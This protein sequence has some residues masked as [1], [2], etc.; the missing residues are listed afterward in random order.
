M[1]CWKLRCPWQTPS[2]K[3][4]ATI[5]KAENDREAAAAARARGE[6]EIIRRIAQK[7][8]DSASVPAAIAANS[9]SS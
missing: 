1:T 5:L 3:V 6:A 4:C 9:A 8:V 2:N 7:S